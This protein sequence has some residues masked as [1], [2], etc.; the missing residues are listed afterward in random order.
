MK[1]PRDIIR[2]FLTCVI[3]VSLGLVY[4]M[5]GEQG[6]SAFLVF[7]AF[8]TLI[9]FLMKIGQ[10]NWK[11][12]Q[13][14]MFF[15]FA[16]LAEMLWLGWVGIALNWWFAL[17]FMGAVCTTW[18]LINL[19]Y[20]YLYQRPVVSKWNTAYLAWK[21]GGSPEDYLKEIQ[22]CEAE[23]KGD[24]GIMIVYNGIPLNDY[25]SIQKIYL[26]KEM[27]QY[28]ECLVLLK[29]TMPRIQ[30]PEA[31]EALSEVERELLKRQ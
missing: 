13:K 25:I 24:T 18:F 17:G 26:L 3:M 23:L 31:Q 15:F 30:N 12:S 4:N 11:R 28:Q 2:V 19:V 6:Y 14:T 29:N 27:E 5:E 9:F 10:S 22:Q 20:T 16:S 21:A 1:D 8:V 7:M